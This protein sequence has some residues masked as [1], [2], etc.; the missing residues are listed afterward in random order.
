MK[1]MTLELNRD[2]KCEFTEY[3]K[4]QLQNKKVTNSEK[5]NTKN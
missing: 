1:Q 3:Q 4:Q 5:Y 2:Q